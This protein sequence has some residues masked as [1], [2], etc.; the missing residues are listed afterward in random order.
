ML[1]GR[2]QIPQL[3]RKTL[4]GNCGSSLLGGG[5]PATER[6]G[7]NKGG[8]DPPPTLVSPCVTIIIII[9]NIQ[10]MIAIIMINICYHHNNIHLS[11]NSDISDTFVPSIEK[12]VTF[13]YEYVW[14]KDNHF[15]VLGADS[16]LSK[17]L[18]G[19]HVIFM[20]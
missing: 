11:G 2:Y 3:E 19:H 12:Y 4:E 16:N 17:C 8:Q 1:I 14:I 6:C 15:D 13:L 20:Y 10:A 7:A 9:I 18:P 5:L